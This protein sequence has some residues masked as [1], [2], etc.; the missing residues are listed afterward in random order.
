MYVRRV[1]N[2]LNNKRVIIDWDKVSKNGP[3]KT[4]GRQLLK[5][6][7]WSILEYFVPINLM[8]NSYKNG[9]LPGMSEQGRIQ[10][11]FGTLL[12]QRVISR[13]F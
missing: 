1:Q 6:F 7:T 13:V 11:F 5:N 4:C 9:V 10:R 8:P 12:F 2:S 3:S